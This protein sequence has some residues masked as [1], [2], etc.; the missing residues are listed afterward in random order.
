[1]DEIFCG[2]Y[3]MA[4]I[5]C[6]MAE[7]LCGMAEILCSMA[8]IAKASPG[9]LGLFRPTR[10][11]AGANPGCFRPAQTIAHRP[12]FRRPSRRPR[13]LRILYAGIVMRDGYGRAKL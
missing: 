6:G 5:V 2:L 7:I 3:G 12:G 11:M 10:L 8:G 1:M 13:R 9:G 4:E